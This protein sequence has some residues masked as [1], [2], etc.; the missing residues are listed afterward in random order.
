MDEVTF[1]WET[2]KAALV[3]VG[4]SALQFGPREPMNE[5]FPNSTLFSTVKLTAEVTA[6]PYPN[7]PVRMLFKTVPEELT[8]APKK[9]TNH[10]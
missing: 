8:F 6:I 3:G 7:A 2:I 10:V 1:A 4:S 5:V 9:S